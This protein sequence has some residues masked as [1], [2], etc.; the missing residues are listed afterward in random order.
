MTFR[1]RKA[2]VPVGLIEIAGKPAALRMERTK[3]LSK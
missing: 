2:A 1:L 3:L